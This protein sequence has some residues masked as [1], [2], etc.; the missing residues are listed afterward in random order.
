MLI[1]NNILRLEGFIINVN[2]KKAYID[3]YKTEIK[4]TIR[5]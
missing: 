5:P 2:N 1:K 4:I 3:S